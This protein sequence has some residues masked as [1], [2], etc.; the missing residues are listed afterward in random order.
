MESIRNSWKYNKNGIFN[1]K[2]NMIE[3]GEGG[4]SDAV[5]PMAEKVCLH[6][7][8]AQCVLVRINQTR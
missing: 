5:F 6:S 3:S 2:K 7:N 8:A 1:E 4:F